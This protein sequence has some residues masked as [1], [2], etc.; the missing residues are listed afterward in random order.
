MTLR[1]SSPGNR[2]RMTGLMP[3]DP[4]PV[5][6]GTTGTVTEVHEDVGQI[7]V[8]WDGIY[9]LILLMGNPLAFST[10]TRPDHGRI[11]PVAN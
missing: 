11:H 3:D 8:D 10:T 9:S 5:P 1:I 4:A 6:V 2:I 7:F